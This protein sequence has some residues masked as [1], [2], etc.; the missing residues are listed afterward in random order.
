[1]NLVIGG[2]GFLGGEIVRQLLECGE[3]VRV[4]CRRRQPVESDHAEIV[5][6]NLSD[7]QSLRNACRGVETVYHTASL[8]SISVHWKPFYE[9][10]IVGTQNVIDACRENGVRRLIYTSSASVTFNGQPQ[11][12][13]DESA[14]YPD[15]WLAHYPHSKAVAEKMILDAVLSNHQ[16][17]DIPFLT[18]VLRPHLIIGHRDR[19]LFPRLFS[20]AEQGRLFRVGDGSNLIDI[21]FVENAALA[22]LQAANALTDSA[23]PVNGNVYYISQGK[24]VNCW[25]W[26]DEILTIKRLPKVQRS[27]SLKTAWRLGW[28]FESW[29][30]LFRLSGEPLMTRFLAAQLAQTHYL[31][32]SKAKKDFG[33]E[34]K[35]SY[36]EGMELLRQNLK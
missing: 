30:K 17:S 4:F 24:P 15:Y 28:V 9:T 20:R 12:G 8:P 26:I 3:K 22:H 7:R 14:P 21:I 5:L 6:G 19:H 27:I 34:P 18:C 33:Y 23:S 29:Y 10:N 32:I 13:V 16:T 11:H 2:T 31:N 1:M 25:N 35:L 36:E